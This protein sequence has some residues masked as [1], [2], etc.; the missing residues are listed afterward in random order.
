[1]HPEMDDIKAIKK[2]YSYKASMLAM[3]AIISRI[4]QREKR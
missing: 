2:Q 4:A 1:M 3:P